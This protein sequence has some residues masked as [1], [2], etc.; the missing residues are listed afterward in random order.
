MAR[1]R[2]TRHRSGQGPEARVGP[3]SPGGRRASQHHLP[4]QV[5]GCPP[6][7]AEEAS[8]DR[9]E[10]MRHADGDEVPALVAAPVGSVPDVVHVGRGPAAPRDLTAP[11]V[12]LADLAESC[13][14]A[15]EHPFPRCDEVFRDEQ[16]AFFLSEPAP[17]GGSPRA[18]RRIQEPGDARGNTGPSAHPPHTSR[19]KRLVNRGRCCSLGI[20]ESVEPCRTRPGAGRTRKHRRRVTLGSAGCLSAEPHD[21]EPSGVASVCAR[22]F[23]RSPIAQMRRGFLQFVAPFVRRPRASCHA[24][25]A[26]YG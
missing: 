14:P 21:S 11:A 16:D 5:V 22:E 7:H 24:P 23:G 9:V 26:R 20:V 8:V 13:A 6:P 25:F 18:E 2:L 12:A 1:S 19:M 4:D 3:G 10:V 17:G 15:A